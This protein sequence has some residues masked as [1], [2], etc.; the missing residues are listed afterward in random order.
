MQVRKKI[1]ALLVEKQIFLDEWLSVANLTFQKVELIP[2][3]FNEKFNT[4]LELHPDLLLAYTNFKIQSLSI[5]K[6][7]W[8]EEWLSAS[9]LTFEQVELIPERFNEKFNTHLALEP[10]LLTTY[11]NFVSQFKAKQNV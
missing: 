8:F 5:E 9:N 2:S 10:N 1:R 7:L 3:Y 11:T 4:R 6:Q